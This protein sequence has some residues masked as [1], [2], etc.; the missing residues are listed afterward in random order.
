MKFIKINTGDRLKDL[1]RI[2]LNILRILTR[3]EPENSIKDL[4][5]RYKDY[6]MWKHQ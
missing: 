6:E 4:L 2:K 1:I 5:K 3:Y